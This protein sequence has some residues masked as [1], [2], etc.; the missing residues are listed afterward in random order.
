MRKGVTFPFGHPSLRPLTDS[1]EGGVDEEIIIDN[2]ALAL[3][4]NGVATIQ[5][6]ASNNTTR[7]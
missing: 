4:L 7:S 6:I 2:A 1:I 3:C 5:E